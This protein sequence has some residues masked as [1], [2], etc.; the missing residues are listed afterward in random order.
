MVAK[1]NY[2]DPSTISRVVSIVDMQNPKLNIG[3]F[4]GVLLWD[5][6]NGISVKT[7]NGTMIVTFL[8]IEDVNFYKLFSDYSK[9]MASTFVKD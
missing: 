1:T 6:G 8:A 3:S 5:A 4:K 2:T 7:D 9:F